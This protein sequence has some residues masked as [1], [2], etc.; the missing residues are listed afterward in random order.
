MIPFVG[1][2]PIGRPTWAYDGE[3]FVDGVYAVTC[4]ASGREL[5]A[6]SLC[7]RCHA[8]DGLARALTT[9]NQWPVPAGCSDP[10]CGGE[11]S[12]YLAFLPARVD[13]EGNRA[14]KPGTTTEPHDDG[15]HGVRA[16]CRDCGRTIV[17]WTDTCPL[18]GAP[19]PLR[20][21]PGQS[22]LLQKAG[23]E[24]RGARLFL[25]QEDGRRERRESNP[26]KRIPETSRGA[27][28]CT[29]IART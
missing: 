4:A 2:E 26:A 19:G 11:E 7:P 16:A 9:A 20:T 10:S 6:S 29:K 28:V 17:E 21:R 22:E 1:G 23:Y 27:P 5:F 25:P 13:Y 12:R 24:V 15:V 3:K 18:C 8:L 14:E